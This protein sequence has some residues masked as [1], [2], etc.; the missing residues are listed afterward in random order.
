VPATEKIEESRAE[1][2]KTSE[3]LSPSAKIEVP[4]PMMTP[5]EKKNG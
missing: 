5:Q 4:K 3:I 1:E 2:I